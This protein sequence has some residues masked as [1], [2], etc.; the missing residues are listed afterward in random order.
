MRKLH[1]FLLLLFFICSSIRAQISYDA[2]REMAI[3]QVKE[4]I[5]AD[6]KKQYNY[7]ISKTVLNN[8]QI[9]GQT[10]NG[11]YWMLF[12]DQMPGANWEHPCKYAFVST[13]DKGGISCVVD[14][15]CPPSDIDLTRCDKNIR[16]QAGAPVKP[17]V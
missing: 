15:V 11:S 8:P 2:S 16:T 5:K 13:T 9:Q 1:I 3:A 17:C 7:Y 4:H 10:L 12:V 14:S 6:G